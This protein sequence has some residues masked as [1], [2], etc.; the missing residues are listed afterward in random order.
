[1]MV[2]RECGLLGVAGCYSVCGFIVLLIFALYMHMKDIGVLMLGLGPGALAMHYALCDQQ[3]DQPGKCL[4]C[5]RASAHFGCIFKASTS[6][7]CA[8]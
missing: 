8:T 3:R 1:M 2:E 7:E 4:Y 5:A 6:T